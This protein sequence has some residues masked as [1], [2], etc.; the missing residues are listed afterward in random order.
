MILTTL[1]G[2][3]SQ[4]A[5]DFQN[6]VQ[7]AVDQEFGQSASAFTVQPFCRPVDQNANRYTVIV[8]FHGVEIAEDLT[9][10]SLSS[11]DDTWVMFRNQATDKIIN[12]I[13]SG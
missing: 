4:A 9:S 6:H 7:A 8:L 11:L 12:A 13:K 2:R 10:Q 1:S 3:F 5:N